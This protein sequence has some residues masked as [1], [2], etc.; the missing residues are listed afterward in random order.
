[1]DS[2][3]CQLFIF[4]A[5]F[6]R[7][8]CVSISTLRNSCILLV[9]QYLFRPSDRKFNRFQ[10]Q[11][12]LCN[13]SK[14]FEKEKLQQNFLFTFVSHHI[15][16]FLITLLC[17]LWAKFLSEVYLYHQFKRWMYRKNNGNSGT[18]D[19]NMNDFD[20]TELV[21]WWIIYFLIF[22]SYSCF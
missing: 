16:K 5:G 4:F 19:G 20:E 13:F 22:N 8:F 14:L 15:F 21:K 2:D 11:F 6:S 9:Y 18:C 1:M 12:S 3:W 7:L 17:Y 10:S